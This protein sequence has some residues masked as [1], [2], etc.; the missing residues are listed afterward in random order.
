MA[1]RKRVGSMNPVY[2]DLHI[3]T[4][5]SPEHL[6]EA[7]DVETLRQRLDEAAGGGE[8]LV[9]LTDHNTV[10]KSA[11]LSAN[12]VLQNVLLGAE[13]HVRNY[14]EASPYHCHIFFRNAPI[15]AALI[16]RVNQVL[17]DLY[18]RKVVGDPDDIPK[19]ED[20]ARQFDEF[21]FVLLPHGG[22]SHSTFDGSIP[23]GVRFDS[24]VERS[25]YYNHFDGFTARSTTGLERT[26]DY[27]ER[28]GIRAFINLITS[29]DN[30]SPEKYPQAKAS[31]AA[32]FVPTWMLA[33]PTFNGLR[34]SLSESDRLVYGDRPDAWAEYIQHVSLQNEFIDVDVTLA[35]GLNVVIGGSSSGK[36]LFVDSVYRK[37]AGTLTESVYASTPYG[38]GDIGVQ[39]PS[40]QTP[41]Y[42]PQNYIMKVCDQ[43]DRNNTVDKITLLKNVFPGDAAERKTIENGISELGESLQQM[44]QAAA[45][46]ERLEDTLRRIPMLSG[47]IITKLIKRNPLKYLKPRESEIRTFQYSTADRARHAKTLKE[48]D[49][50]L[51]QNPFVRHDSALVAGINAELA[52]AL[53]ASRAESQVRAIVET[54]ANRIDEQQKADDR[55]TIT[56]RANFGQLLK[57]IRHYK[58]AFRLFYAA[59][60]QI[61]RFSIKSA[62]KEIVSMGHRLSI[63][64]EFELTKEKFLEILNLMLTKDYQ[65]ARFEDITPGA[66]ST[67]GFRQRGPQVNDHDG[68]Q[69]EVM[70]KFRAINQKTY[71]IVTKDGKDF[72]RLSAGWKTSVILDLVLGCANDTAPLIIDQPED[73]LATT[74]INAGLL[75]AIK[76]C[77][78]GRQI[79]LVSH[80]AT[81]PML[82]DAQNVVLC[83]NDDKFITIRSSPLEGSLEGRDVVDIIANTTDGGKVSIKKRV[84]KYNLKRFRGDDE[85][86]L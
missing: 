52:T 15:D 29:T 28:L 33:S 21:E 60:D 80:N 51:A 76:K 45:D 10:N 32:A 6:N 73:N 70:A 20:I 40:V 72:D 78:A 63:E 59:R 27:F 31:D 8:Y 57:S 79:I 53:A 36:T 69:R 61:S 43:N 38:I 16:D 4:S 77:K 65:I 30:Y 49:A 3:H 71:R 86:D 55:E 47:L 23:Q 26:Q 83:R 67:Q 42:L 12:G 5:E 56:K 13:L 22:Q 54:Y 2:L 9:S 81:I 68:L 37:I 58:R 62:T 17:D 14:D 19:I 66:L 75:Q 84:K 48:I 39:N 64:N 82:G 46:I 7:Y 18:P 74:Y 35:P 34:L 41:H 24:T 1:R 25:V 11:Y 44:V 50:F 85:A